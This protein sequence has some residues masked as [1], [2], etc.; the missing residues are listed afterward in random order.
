[1]PE[2]SSV[3]FMSQF[4]D[5]V[6]RDAIARVSSLYS[7]HVAPTTSPAMLVPM[8]RGVKARYSQWLKICLFRRCCVLR[9]EGRKWR[10]IFS[11]IQS[12]I[13]NLAPA[14]HIQIRSLKLAWDI[15]CFN[16]T[17]RCFF[18]RT[19]IPA[20]VT[21]H[22]TFSTGLWNGVGEDGRLC[23]M[24]AESTSLPNLINF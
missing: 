12:A 17:S 20:I 1:M 4:T 3:L 22:L 10:N 19:S 16:F 11:W 15:Y 14:H 5:E 6:V 8:A 9:I 24:S 13:P 2:A 21:C 7:V 23:A 18:L